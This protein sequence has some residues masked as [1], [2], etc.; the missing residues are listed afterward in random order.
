MAINPD[1]ITTIRVDQLA[2]GILNVT[3]E[4]AHANGTQL[5]KA[6]IQDLVDLVS[7]AVGVGSGVGYL[8]LSV[9]DGQQL[10]DVPTD[11]SFFLCGKGTFLNINGF[12]NIVCTKELNAIMSLS[13]HWSLAVEIP[14]APLSGTVQTV[15]GSAVDNTDPLNPVINSTGGGGG[16]Q[17]LSD[18][19][20]NGNIMGAIPIELDTNNRTYLN[21]SLGNSQLSSDGT[22]GLVAHDKSGAVSAKFDNRALYASSGFSSLDWESR[23]LY[24][25]SGSVT[26]DWSV[27]PTSILTTTITDGDTTHAPDGN[28][29]FD[30]LANKEPTITAGTVSQYWRGDKTWQTLPNSSSGGYSISYYLNGGT[31]ASVATYYQM[32]KIAV[33]G[34]GVDFSLAGNGLISQW[35]TDVADPNRLEIPAGNWNFEMYMSASSVGGTPSFYVELLKYNG[36]TFTTIANS[37]AVPEAI[38]SG[39]LIDLYL[40]SLAVPQTTL[41]VTD[42]LAIRVYIVNSTGGR[43]ITMHTQDSHLCQ[44]ITNF[45]GGVSALNG[46]T[47]NTQYLA[48][49]TIGSDFNINSATDTHTFN[50]PTA[51]ATN[52]GALSS[53]DWSTFNSKQ[54]AFMITGAFSGISPNDATTYYIGPSSGIVATTETS[55]RWKF[56]Y[57]STI[58][59]LSLALGQGTAGTN[60]AVSV[61]LRNSTAGTETLIGTF[62]SD[63]TAGQGAFFNFPNLSIAI[64]NTTDNWTLKLVTPTWA[65]NPIAWTGSFFIVIN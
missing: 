51:S 33:I 15:T 9:T 6:T 62:T 25:S 46:L 16:S 54:N 48:V 19:L 3:N 34:T 4:F 50:L 40:T 64:P 36:T 7:T 20:V 32:S 18:T 14:I 22:D 26:L 59:T 10:P 21:N 57:A 63:F 47:A 52:R 43:T 53:T 29:V 24:D 17:N 31:A 35:L 55:R 28:S 30:A 5:E 13:D 1:N 27:A 56:P 45:A 65:T 23:K 2:T 58:R 39:T 42:R 12:P 49:G 38:T 61:Y 8:P 44:V 60:E 37:S 41:L 11:P